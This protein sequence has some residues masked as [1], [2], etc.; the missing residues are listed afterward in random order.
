MHTVPPPF[1]DQHKVDAEHLKLLS[2]FHFVGAGLAV[3]ALLFLALHFTVMNTVFGN[4]KM[5]QDPKNAPPFSPT[6]F[7]GIMRVFY[8]VGAA[9][10]VTS[11]VLNVLAGLYLRARKH[12][13][14]TLV[15]AALNCLH[16]PLGTTLGVF[17]IIV[18]LRESVRELYPDSPRE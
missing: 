6:E 14:F 11:G 10:L 7:M 5:W 16:M 18:L 8:L 3:L 2:I 17:T 15:V 1:R 12:R 13:T 9:W 4:P